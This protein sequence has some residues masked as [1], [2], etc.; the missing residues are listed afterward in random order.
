MGRCLEKVIDEKNEAADP[1][2][3]LKRT[4]KDQKGGKGGS[5]RIH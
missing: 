5:K 1:K 3:F 2:Y 4:R